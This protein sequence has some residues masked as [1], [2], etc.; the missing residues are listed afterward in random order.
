MLGVGRTKR[1]VGLCLEMDIRW[2]NGL[3]LYSAFFH[4]ALFCPPKPIIKGKKRG[5]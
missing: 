3:L 2:D 1:L 4:Y 5:K